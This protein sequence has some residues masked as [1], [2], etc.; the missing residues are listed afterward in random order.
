MSKRKRL[1]FNVVRE[2]FPEMSRLLAFKWQRARQ[3]YEKIF[4]LQTWSKNTTITYFINWT[5]TISLKTAVFSKR[6]VSK[7]HLYHLINIGLKFNYTKVQDRYALLEHLYY[8]FSYQNPPKNQCLIASQVRWKLCRAVLGAD[9]LMRDSNWY[10]ACCE[11]DRS[12]CNSKLTKTRMR[13]SL[14]ELFYR[15]FC[16]SFVDNIFPAMITKQKKCKPAKN[17][18]RYFSRFIQCQKMSYAGWSPFYSAIK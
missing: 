6:E 7:N 5:W 4:W 9:F 17:A 11:S 13:F 3:N 18:K 14:F 10:L 2:S 8:S 16:Y 15:K 1:S 12:I